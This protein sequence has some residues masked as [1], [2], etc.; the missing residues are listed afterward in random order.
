M[1]LMT[2]KTYEN[3][4]NAIWAIDSMRNVIIKSLQRN[5]VF[6]IRSILI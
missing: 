3:R 4:K 1:I 6:L 2:Y 5:Q